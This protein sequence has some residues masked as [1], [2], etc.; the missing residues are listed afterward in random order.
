M[1]GKHGFLP[2]VLTNT[3]MRLAA[4]NHNLDCERIEKPEL[5]NPKLED[6]TKGSELLQF[7]EDH[8]VRWQEYTVQEVVDYTAVE[9]IISAVD[10]QYVEELEEDYFGYKNQAI[11]TMINQLQTWNVITTKEKM[12]L[13]AHFLAQ[14]SNMPDAHVTTFALELDRLQVECKYHRVKVTKTNKVDHFVS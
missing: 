6:Y 3:K 13:K 10:A 12:S 9:A 2:L 7:K 14:W 1:G 4:G 8:K 5:L 11:K